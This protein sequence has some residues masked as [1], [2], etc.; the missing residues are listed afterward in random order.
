MTIAIAVAFACGWLTNI[1]LSIYAHRSLAHRAVVL[2]QV[3]LVGQQEADG[4][5]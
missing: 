5:A 3:G 2:H 4:A 1:S